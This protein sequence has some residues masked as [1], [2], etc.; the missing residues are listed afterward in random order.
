MSGSNGPDYSPVGGGSGAADCASYRREKPLQAPNGDVVPMLRV[1]D[2]LDVEL[3]EDPVLVV[4]V[5]TPSGREAG[6]IVPDGQLISCLQNGV[7]FSATV[8]SIRGGHVMF[9]IEAT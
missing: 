5:V 8:T 1:G 6:A 7:A 2:V 3:Q 4:A 9:R